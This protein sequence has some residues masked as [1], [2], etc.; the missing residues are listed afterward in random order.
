M[1][2]KMYDNLKWSLLTLEPA[3]VT[4]ISGLGIALKWDTS[5]I[6]TII[7]LVSTFLG[8]ITGISSINYKK[9][10]ENEKNY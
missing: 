6:V 9:E 1:S 2:N 7:G 10:N 4:L 5:L 3:L 8:T